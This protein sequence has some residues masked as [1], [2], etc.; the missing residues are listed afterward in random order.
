MILGPEV[1][2]GVPKAERPLSC[3]TRQGVPATPQIAG[4]IERENC[5][6]RT[7]VMLPRG[8]KTLLA[9]ARSK[10][11]PFDIVLVD[12]TSRL[13]RKLRDAL[14]IF[15]ELAYLGVRL[16]FVGQGI[17]TESEQ[18]EVLLATHGIVDSLYIRELSKK[19]Y[20]GVEGRALHGLHTGVRCFGYRNE[21][22][23][24]A[25]QR[26]PYGRPKINGVRLIVEPRHAEIVRRIFELYASGFS[27]K[28]IAKKLNAEGVE[29]PQPQ[30]GR[31]SQSW[32]PSSIRKILHNDRYRGIVIWGKTKKKR[33]PSTGKRRNEQLAPSEWKMV[34][35][36]DQRIIS[37]DLWERV[38]Q[39]LD[40]VK[41][42]YGDA[43][44]R[45]G[46]LRAVALNSPTYSRAF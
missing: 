15:D 45:A 31:L 21:P 27:L 5:V 42:V 30:R 41:A 9:T 24:D 46:L 13:S 11:R 6:V 33:D 23:E 19:V 8:L 17:D 26:D 10:P 1:A 32:C 44:R 18:A 34:E 20:R 2:V 35:A 4:D 16:L 36:P 43:G 39:W 28:R 25:T 40:Q 29:S 14:G 12:D 37:D 3:G 38:Q 7:L 22:I